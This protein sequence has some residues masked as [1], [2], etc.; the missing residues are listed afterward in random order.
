MDTVLTYACFLVA[1]VA[2]GGTWS[3]FKARNQLAA[4]ILAAIALLAA[5]AGIVRLL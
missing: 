5:V 3:M 1:G 2:V 4:G